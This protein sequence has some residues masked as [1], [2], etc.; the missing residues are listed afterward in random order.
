MAVSAVQTGP[1]DNPS[2]L[3]YELPMGSG[4]TESS[5]RLQGYSPTRGLQ[6]KTQRHEWGGWT[7]GE[8]WGGQGERKVREVGG[9]RN[10]NVLHTCMKFS[11]NELNSRGRGEYF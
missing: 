4:G 10:H 7:C 8:E 5:H 2:L 9:E 11:K 3:D 1:V 6:N